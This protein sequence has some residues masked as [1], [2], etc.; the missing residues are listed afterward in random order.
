MWGL[1]QKEFAIASTAHHDVG[2]AD[3]EVHQLCN[4]AAGNANA[5]GGEQMNVNIVGDAEASMSV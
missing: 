4:C 3:V 1:S 2:C 5:R